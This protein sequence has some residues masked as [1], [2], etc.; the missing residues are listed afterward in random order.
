MDD[1]ANAPIDAHT[2]IHEAGHV[3]G[4][5]DY[6]NYDR[7][8]NYGAA[9]GFNMQDYNV[10]EHDPYSRVALGW[11]DPIV[12]SG[13]TTLT[14]TPGEAIILSPNNLSAAS[15]FDEYLNS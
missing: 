10:G 12:P 15:P 4:L 6:Y 7:T 5:E 13:N 14:I 1:S 2:Y 11:I 8:S 3:L 9:G